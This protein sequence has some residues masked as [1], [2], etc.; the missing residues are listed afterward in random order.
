[1]Q[2]TRNAKRMAKRHQDQH[3]TQRIGWLRPAVLGANDGIVSTA[4][5][6]LGVAAANADHAAILVAGIAGLVAG[7]ASMAAGEYVSVRSQT[8]IEKAEVEIERQHIEEE[9]EFER[10]ELKAI[11]IAR[12][13]DAALASKV[14]DQLMAHD[15]LGA[16]VRD[17]L[18]ISE[19][20]R[21][22][23]VQAAFT[24]A[25][26]FATGAALPIV[27]AALSPDSGLLWIV[28]ATSLL[29]LAFLGGLAA[30]AGGAPLSTA[31]M[32]VTFWGGIAMALTAGVGALIGAPA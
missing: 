10:E 11:Y 2:S 28:F 17:E 20:L 29:F 16:H 23:P 1:M 8:D 3:R 7:A 30:H 5:L 25:G 21:A 13:L 6:L 24:S 31:A 18:G 4:S 19:T 32:R 27:A 12:G 9:P 22:R 15:A 14:A 26:S